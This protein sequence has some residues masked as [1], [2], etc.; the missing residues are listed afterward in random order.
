SRQTKVRR[1]EV[2]ARAPASPCAPTQEYELRLTGRPDTSCVE[3]AKRETRESTI[4][5]LRSPAARSC[6]TRSYS[7]TPASLAALAD[8]PRASPKPCAAAPPSS[9]VFL[10]G[11]CAVSYRERV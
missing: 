4:S 2:C 9:Q 6:R 5:E 11:C 7:A 8:R 3:M 10:A 1:P